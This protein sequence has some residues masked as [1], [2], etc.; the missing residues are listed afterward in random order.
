[1]NQSFLS[2]WGVEGMVWARAWRVQETLQ[3]AVG[4]LLRGL[5]SPVWRWYSASRLF[6]I[7]DEGI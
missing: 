2:E 7:F 6:W 4:L 3:G 5:V 1:M